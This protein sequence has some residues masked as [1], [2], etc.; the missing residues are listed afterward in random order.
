MITLLL[1]LLRLLL[2]LF[3]AH[4]QLALANLAL[5]H[6]LT[7]Y[8]RTVARPRLRKIDRPLLGW[9]GE[10]LGRLERVPR[11]RDAGHRPAVAAPTLPR[12][13]DSAV[14]SVHGRPP[15]CQCRD[16]SP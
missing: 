1:Q 9:P 16:H 3:G 8:K 7:V 4:R 6:Q 12:V 11:D 2:F 14:R 15:S 10:S 13:L 5:R